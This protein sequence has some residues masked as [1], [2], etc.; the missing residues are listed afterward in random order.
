MTLPIIANPLANAL[1]EAL[2]IF[3]VLSFLLFWT[4]TA[5]LLTS[6]SKKLGKFTYWFLLSIPL[7]YFLSQF[8]AFFFNIFEGLLISNPT[9]YGII[10]TLLFGFSATAGGILFGIAFWIISR[11]LASDNPVKD[12]TLIAAFG[13]SLFFVSDQGG[14]VLY[15]IGGLYPPFGLPTVSSMALSSY[16]MLVGI[17]SSAISVAQDS[18]VRKLIRKSVQEEVRLLDTIGTAQMQK[19]IE[20]KVISFAKRETTDL[21]EDSG[22]EPSLSESEIQGYLEQVLNE[23]KR[24]VGKNETEPH[25]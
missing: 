12:Y 8:P 10:F 9:L 2:T 17:Y 18:K 6:Y 5:V 23:V 14:S 24:K 16:F 1:N 13:I 21:V 11:H 7:F 20:S 4:A 3:T 22:I 15:R 25:Q 19:E